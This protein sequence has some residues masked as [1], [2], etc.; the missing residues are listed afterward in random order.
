MVSQ[1]AALTEVTSAST[2]AVRAGPPPPGAVILMYDSKPRTVGAV[3]RM[4]PEWQTKS[5]GA[6]PG[7]GRFE[8]VRVEPFS[9]VVGRA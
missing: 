6:I 1:Q 3:A 2:E 4:L 5:L 9:S 7:A 8:E